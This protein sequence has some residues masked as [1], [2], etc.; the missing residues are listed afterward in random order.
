[1][2]ICRV[3]W[4]VRMHLA[5]PPQTFLDFRHEPRDVSIECEVIDGANL[6]SYT[7][8]DYGWLNGTCDVEQ[9]RVK[10]V[11]PSR[12]K[13]VIRR[14][15]RKKSDEV[16]SGGVVDTVKYTRVHVTFEIEDASL[17]DEE[18]KLTE[19]RLWV[20]SV[21]QKFVDLY[22]LVTSQVDITRPRVADAPVVDFL[23]A[24]EYQFG[25][26]EAVVPFRGHM[27]RLNWED[28]KNIN[29]FKQDMSAEELEKLNS[30]LR[31]GKD[32]ALHNQLLLDSKEQSFVRGAHDLSIMIAQ[33]AF[34]TFLQTKL[35]AW[36]AVKGQT[37]LK[38]GGSKRGKILPYQQAIEK[39]QL[40]ELL[41]YVETLSKENVKGS[42]QHD[43]W[44]EYAYEK[45][46][47]IVHRG[48]RGTT[49]DD[50]RKA[51]NSVTAYMR[52]IESTLV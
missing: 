12:D 31:G 13:I 26:S 22:R 10:A 11:S 51:F 48:V 4:P 7:G 28:T 1:M 37:T 16:F 24:E 39:A 41:N 17:L 5:L 36:C 33:T 8:E 29:F 18:A 44:E 46:N 49:Q 9:E 27:R 45:R 52:L 50:A 32:V 43:D 6:Y 47:G 19:L 23:I 42:T 14:I 30:L 25:D 34:E 20:E 35:I 15:I 2:S 3:I 40:R 21:V 38:V